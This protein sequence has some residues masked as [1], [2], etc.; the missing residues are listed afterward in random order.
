MR[1]TTLPNGEK[2]KSH[3]DTCFIIE[4][5]SNNLLRFLLSTDYGLDMVPGDGNMKID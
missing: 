5:R 3:E 1:F 2:K 4:I